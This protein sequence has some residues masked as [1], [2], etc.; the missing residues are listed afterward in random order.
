MTNEATM[1]E[2]QWHGISPD[3]GE[4]AVSFRI[5]PPTQR[6][7]GEWSAFVALLPMAPTPQAIFGIDSWQAVD[8]AMRH[9]AVLVTHYHE[10]GWRFYWEPGGDEATP[11]D[12]KR[13]PK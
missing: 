7:D 8:L 12:L 9:V 10:Q 5:G 2:R 6:N 4:H 3:G 11:D 1:I 13:V